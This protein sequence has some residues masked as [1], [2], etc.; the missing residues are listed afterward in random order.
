[1]KIKAIELHRQSRGAMGSRTLSATLTSEGESVG[2]FKAR[3]L[4]KE[5]Q[6]E[7]KQPRGHQYKKADKP[8]I[9]A[10]NH[11]AREFTVDAPNKV[12]CGDVTY[13][14]A[15][16]GWLYL[17]LVIDLYSRRIVGWA[18]SKHPDTELTMKALRIAYELRGKPTQ[19]MF[20]SDQGCHYTS[21]AFQQLLWRYQIKQS[22][23]RRGNCWDNAPMER[24][25]RSFKYEWMPKNYY[26]SYEDAQNDIMLYLKYYNGDRCHSYNEYLTPI[27]AEA[28]VA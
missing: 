4:M 28:L 20:H 10:D 1:M 25:F 12:W 13:V 27:A 23:S 21:H 14:W 7:S 6:I 17:A 2:R 19:L 26:Q 8:S 9:V 15:G 18:C 24:V 11:L 5:A 16:T 22:M 3:N